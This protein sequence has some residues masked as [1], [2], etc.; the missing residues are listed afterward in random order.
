MRRVAERQQAA[1]VFFSQVDEST[2]L[3][4]VVSSS[5]ATGIAFQELRTFEGCASLTHLVEKTRRRLGAR[6]RSSALR[7]REAPISGR[8]ALTRQPASSAGPVQRAELSGDA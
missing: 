7:C 6:S 1:I 2:I 4:W 5:L 8:A 3:A